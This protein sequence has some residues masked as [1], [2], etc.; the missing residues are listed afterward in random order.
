MIETLFVLFLIA[1]GVIWLLIREVRT[2]EAE[3]TQAR[4]NDNRHPKG[5][6]DSEGNPMGGKFKKAGQ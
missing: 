6:K 4:K 3:L 1:L 5:A 2:L